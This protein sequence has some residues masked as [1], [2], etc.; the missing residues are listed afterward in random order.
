MALSADAGKAVTAPKALWLT[1]SNPGVFIVNV[2]D[3]KTDLAGDWQLYGYVTNGFTNAVW[4]RLQPTNAQCFFRVG[5][6]PGW[7]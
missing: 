3:Y 6:V 1:W 5:R 4:L 7:W 2:V